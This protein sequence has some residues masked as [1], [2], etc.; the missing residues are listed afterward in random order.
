MKNKT[1]FMR[2]ENRKSIF[3]TYFIRDK[4]RKSIFEI[5]FMRDKIYLMG[6]KKNLLHVFFT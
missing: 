5:Y 1:Y 3:E 4:N 2:D 6:D